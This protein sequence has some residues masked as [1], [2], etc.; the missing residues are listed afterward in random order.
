MTTLDS[1]KFKAKKKR[2]GDNQTKKEL[3]NVKVNKSMWQ[4]WRIGYVFCML[5]F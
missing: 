3:I 2:K 1:W 5:V 4:L